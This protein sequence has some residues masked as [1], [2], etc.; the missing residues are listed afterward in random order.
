MQTDVRVERVNV[1]T[2]ENDAFCGHYMA[3]GVS[4]ATFCRTSKN[5][6]QCYNVVRIFL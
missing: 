1:Q 2:F 3:D 6:F 4:T 5:C